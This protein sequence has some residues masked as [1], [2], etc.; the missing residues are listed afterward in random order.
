[1][2]IMSISRL[3]SQ[4]AIEDPDRPCITHKGKTVT[5]QEFDRH[6]NRLARAYQQ[7]GVQHNDFV[8]VALPNSIEFYQACVAIWKLGAT[9]QPVS[10]KLPQRELAAIRGERK[11][12]ENFLPHFV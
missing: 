11:R 4:R 5:R 12:T 6:T 3:I 1:M 2:T 10:A 7:K 8:T 9:P